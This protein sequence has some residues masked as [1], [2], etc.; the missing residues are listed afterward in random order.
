[1]VPPVPLQQH[2]EIAAHS[3]TKFMKLC[4]IVFNTRGY[5]ENKPYGP[6]TCPEFTAEL[7][8]FQIQLRKIQ[9]V[10]PNT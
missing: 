7:S 1:M 4:T 6:H 5:S 10:N 8:R 9:F 2:W 3:C